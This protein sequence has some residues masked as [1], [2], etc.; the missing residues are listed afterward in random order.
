LPRNK[1]ITITNG[2]IISKAQTEGLAN[3]CK[4]IENVYGMPFKDTTLRSYITNL[5]NKLKQFQ[6]SKSRPGMA[7]KI[8]NLKKGY[9]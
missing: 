1:I 8:D 6:K 3:C 7:E 9:L 4:W 2:D 5:V